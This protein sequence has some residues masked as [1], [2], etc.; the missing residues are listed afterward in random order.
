MWMYFCIN[1][2][3]EIYR[4]RETEPDRRKLELLVCVDVYMHGSLSGLKKY[5]LAQ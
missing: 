4:E 2:F 5:I 1:K 3:S